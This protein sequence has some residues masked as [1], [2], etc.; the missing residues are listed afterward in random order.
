MARYDVGCW[1]LCVIL[2]HVGGDNDVPS[3]QMHNKFM[4]IKVYGGLVNARVDELNMCRAIIGF[5]L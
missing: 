5:I 3:L 2:Y 4:S 1:G